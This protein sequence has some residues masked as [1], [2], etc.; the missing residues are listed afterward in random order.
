MSG[1]KHDTQEASVQ[2]IDCI[3]FSVQPKI[4]VTTVI[5][6]HIL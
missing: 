2:T 1:Q 6:V 5:T 4:L 3:F